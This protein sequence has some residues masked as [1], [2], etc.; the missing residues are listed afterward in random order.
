MFLNWQMHQC[1]DY[2]IKLIPLNAPLLFTPLPLP[3][4][5]SSNMHLSG[6]SPL[7]T[8]AS[9]YVLHDQLCQYKPP[10]PEI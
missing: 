1:V 3:A 4:L 9:K 7:I 6:S 10:P 5:A 8:K 2:K